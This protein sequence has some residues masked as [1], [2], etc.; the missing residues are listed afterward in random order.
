VGL[1]LVT[2]HNTANLCH[3]FYLQYA[4]EYWIAR[5]VPCKDGLVHGDVLDPDDG[6]RE[7]LHDFVYH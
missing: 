1:L 4:G 2:G 7:D 6:G 5:E 3:G